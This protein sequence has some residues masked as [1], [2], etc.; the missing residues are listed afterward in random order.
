[1]K[2]TDAKAERTYVAP[3]IEELKIDFQ[4]VLVDSQCPEDESGGG[5]GNGEDPGL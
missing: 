4:A 1:M 5:E 2:K 3:E